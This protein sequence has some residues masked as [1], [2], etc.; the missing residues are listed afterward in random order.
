MAVVPKPKYPLGAPMSAGLDN[1][2]RLGLV[3]EGQAHLTAQDYRPFSEVLVSGHGPYTRDGVRWNIATVD[4][5]FRWE[6][7]E[8]ML[9][10]VE[11]VRQFPTLRQVNLHF[12]PKLW[13]DERHPGGQRGTYDRMVDGFRLVADAAAKS[14]IEIV[15]ENL[16]AH[17]DGIAADASPEGVDWTDRNQSYGASP[18]EWIGICRDIDRAN[19]ALCLDSSHLVTYCHTI[20]DEER[21]TQV[22]MSFL[23]A[24]HMIR[25]VHWNDNYLY[26]SRGRSDQHA[27]LGKGTLP[28]EL[29]RAIKG[30]DATLSIEHFYSI[31][32]LEEELEYIAAL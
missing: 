31:Q 7:L 16:N 2:S 18:D 22:A 20:A 5:A 23:S 26:D 15:L 1:L 24:P 17:W 8:A 6:S 9:D 11:M 28:I 21:R 4:D 13:R 27:L 3:T 25:H 29:H 19:V 12:P 14:G 30:L 10:Y 32:E